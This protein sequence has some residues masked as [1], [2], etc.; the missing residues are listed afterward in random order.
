[1]STWAM[2]QRY[3]WIDARLAAS[4]AFN[5]DDIVRAFTVTKQTATAT[6]RQYQALQPGACRYDA[7]R[8]A[9][10]RDD[11]PRARA[12]NGADVACLLDA[13]AAALEFIEDEAD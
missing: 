3:A 12:L 9:F 13:L 5:R 6:I 10:V 1:M 7:S 11:R 4:A 2:R 8:K